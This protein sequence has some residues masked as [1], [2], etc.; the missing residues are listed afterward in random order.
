MNNKIVPLRRSYVEP[1]FGG[2]LEPSEVA[3]LNSR[4]RRPIRIGLAIIGASVIGLGLWA[5]VTQISSGITAPGQVRVEANRKTLKQREGGVVRS[6]NVREGQFVRT[7][8]VLLQFDDVQARAQNQVDAAEAQ[9]ARFLAEATNRP[10]P[11]FPA[12]LMSRISDPRVAGMIRDQQ[13][14]FTSR[15]A[16]FA[17]QISVLNQR[18]EQQQ[19]SI[20]G[21][22]AQ[23]DSVNEQVRLTQEEL[24]GYKTLYEKGY[25]PKTLILRYERAMADLAGRKGQLV[26]EISKTR[27]QMGET[28]MQLNALK[29]E[30][31]TQAADGLREMQSRLADALPRA[32][33][34]KQ[35]LAGTTIRSPVDGYVLSLSQFT[36]GGVAQ[37]GETL[38]DIVPANA[39]LSVTALIKP[40]DVDSVHVG[41]DAKV[42]LSAFNARWA[43][44]VPAKVT[45]VSADRLTNDKTGE[46]FYRVDLKI[47]PKDVARV[48]NGAKLTP[49]MPADAMIIT[50]KRTIM[51]FLIAPITDTLR[52]A[53][54]EE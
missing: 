50:G 28:R 20:G 52:N 10:A 47:D 24:N 7:G 22:Q 9:S 1:S 46:A 11:E 2:E 3:D 4:V 39:P 37:P 18:L 14:L 5:S 12:D 8:Q 30:R 38:M 41:M 26:A 40:Q 54:R 51:E 32:T 53:F 44:P 36:V 29:N 23:V 15:Q 19:T 6:I 42:R 21:L 25:A 49:G 45:N 48:G 34:A 17:S 13:F 35:T 43:D 33:A 27:E 31:Q 16:L